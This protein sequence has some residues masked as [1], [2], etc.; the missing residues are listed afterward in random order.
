MNSKQVLVIIVIIGVI[1]ICAC[2]IIGFLVVGS[3]N[4]V[5]DRFVSTTTEITPSQPPSSTRVTL[6]T[7][8]STST[9]LDPTPSGETSPV[10]TETIA[11]DPE[12]QAQMDEIEAQAA[13]LRGLRPTGPVDRA[14]LT[15]ADL[16]QRVLDDF[17]DDYTEDEAAD[18]ALVLSLFGLLERDF[19]LFNFYL[20]LYSEQIA[21]FYDDEVKK[22]FVVQ[23]AGF[24]GME[25]ITYAHEI[26]TTS[27]VN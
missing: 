26:S 7:A 5:L 19:D 17:L 3:G 2:S 25:R 8:E 11:I 12:V 16:Y 18:D 6:P 4:F 10:P 1:G 22:M 27:H 9:T 24:R 20:D 15:P 23:E 14:L 21:G 13:S